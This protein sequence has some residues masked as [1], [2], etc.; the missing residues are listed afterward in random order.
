MRPITQWG[1]TLIIRSLILMAMTLAA[2]SQ[3]AS[4]QTE[5]PGWLTKVKFGGDL[6]LRH[7]YNSRP[8][9]TVDRER[10]RERFRLRLGMQTEIEENMKLKLRLASGDNGSPISAN[11]TFDG[12]AGK[13]EIGIDQAMLDWRLHDSTSLR[14]GKI[15]NP[16]RPLGESQIIYDSDYMP[17]GGAL[18]YTLGEVQINFG[19]FIID[20]RAPDA[21]AGSTDPD[22][23]LF[24]VMAKWSND[25]A[26]T[27]GLGY[28]HFTG[29]KDKTPATGANLSF[30]GNSSSGGAYLEDYNVGELL[31]EWKCENGSIYADYLYNFAADENNQAYT[32]GATLQSGRW[33]YGYAYRS[34]DRDAT[35]SALNDSDFGNAIDG[36]FG[37][38]LNVGYELSEKTEAAITAG[39]FQVDGGAGGG[40]PYWVDTVL[41]DLIAKF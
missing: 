19:A 38:L 35:V 1:I 10:H 25:K 5:L 13:K 34:I 11:S 28:H 14:L 16:F 29:I 17:E 39:R 7:D 6:R 22:A 15:D 9:E 4:A 40:T 33:E 12:N 27:V 37:H 8:N 26:L 3:S 32:I 24:P 2:A 23:W 20:E 36:H 31:L 41:V 21:G 30:N 18:I